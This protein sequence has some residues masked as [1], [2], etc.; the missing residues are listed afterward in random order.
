MPCFPYKVTRIF[1]S[2]LQHRNQ[3]EVCT[4]TQVHTHEHSGTGFSVSTQPC[5]KYPILTGADVWPPNRKP[6]DFLLLYCFKS[7]FGVIIIYIY[8]YIYIYAA[9]ILHVQFSKCRL[10]G[11]T[12]KIHN[13]RI[14]SYG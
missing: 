13:L 7:H 3:L 12:L 5:I 6:V 8:I 2:H 11:N 10:D 9:N 1:S 4:I 14:Y